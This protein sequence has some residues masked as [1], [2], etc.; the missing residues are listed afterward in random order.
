M[1]SEI[2]INPDRIA[3]HGKELETDIAPKLEA[4][5][6]TLN[7]DGVYNLE[8]GD[9]SITCTMAAMAYPGALQFMFEDMETHV[10]MVQGFAR[11]VGTTAKNYQSSE[12]ASTVKKV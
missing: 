12:D 3:K 1:G 10:Q 4:V 2:H 9:F 5:R 6:K 7:G 11:G 8:G